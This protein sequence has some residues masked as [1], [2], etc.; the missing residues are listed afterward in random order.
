M[1]QTEFEGNPEVEVINSKHDSPVCQFKKNQNCR[2]VE[3]KC[4]YEKSSKR[5]ESDFQAQTSKTVAHYAKKTASQSHLKQTSLK[6]SV[7]QIW[8]A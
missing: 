1:I 5:A 8:S 4:L 2:K 7:F 3:F 6:S